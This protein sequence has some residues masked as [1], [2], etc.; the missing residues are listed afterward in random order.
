M[1]R[2][3]RVPI[4]PS[5]ANDLARQ[6]L[7]STVNQSLH[8]LSLNSFLSSTLPSASLPSAPSVS[9]T[10][11][12]ADLHAAPDHGPSII[13]SSSTLSSVE[14][15]RTAPV[16]NSRLYQHHLS[17]DDTPRAHGH[18]HSHPGQ[19]KAGWTSA[20]STRPASPV[21]TAGH[22]VSALSLGDG[23][24]ARAAARRG[25]GEADGEFDPE[26]SL[27]R[28]VGE[29]GRA[30]GEVRLPSLPSILGRTDP[31]QRLQARPVSP[32]S[33]TR[34]P[35][36]PSPLPSM[37]NPSHPSKPRSKHRNPSLSLTLSRADPLPSPPTSRSSSG[38]GS[39]SHEGLKQ[40]GPV[41]AAAL[42]SGFS[43]LARQLDRELRPARVEVKS[44][45]SRAPLGETNRHNIT[46]NAKAGVQQAQKAKGRKGLADVT[47][48][49]SFMRTPGKGLD[50]G[51]LG[52][53]GDVGGEGD[54]QS[55]CLFRPMVAG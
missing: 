10:G 21:S 17:A 22:H 32:F 29:L 24:F 38:S 26:R 28:L 54:G 18:L 52:R 37:L 19:G 11:S 13:S 34:S 3:P 6:R 27:G 48:M 15:P 23:V 43:S 53:D 14:Y 20:V 50:H 35:R 45:P 44:A 41:S 46:A 33:P 4:I 49:S 36:S 16:I 42:N 51:T 25:G 2:V 47:G 40:P 30:M 31:K 7:E 1:D 8:S 9:D 55:H 5:S 39:T 12:D